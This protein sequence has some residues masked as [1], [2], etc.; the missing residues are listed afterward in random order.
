MKGFQGVLRASGPSSACLGAATASSHPGQEHFQRTP[1]CGTEAQ[2]VVWQQGGG[3]KAPSPAGTPGYQP[4]RAGKGPQAPGNAAEV[5]RIPGLHL[6]SKH[7]HKTRPSC[8]NVVQRSPS[9]A[10]MA[11]H[12]LQRLHQPLPVSLPAFQPS[13]HRNS[14]RR[15]SFLSLVRFVLCF[16]ELRVPLG[17]AAGLVRLQSGAGLSSRFLH[18]RR[19]RQGLLQPH[20][21]GSERRDGQCLPSIA[22][23]RQR[24]LPGLF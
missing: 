12:S 8:E 15:N 2:S 14:W 13:R 9:P 19:P 6:A 7:N 21:F 22:F 16:P 24:P 17:S 5:I 3:R 23:P 10:S 11:E 4:V 18:P 20:I 1:G